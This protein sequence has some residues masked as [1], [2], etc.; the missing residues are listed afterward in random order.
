MRYLADITRV[1]FSDQSL[2]D[3]SLLILGSH[4]AIK[5]LSGTSSALRFGC[6]VAA[7]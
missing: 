7:K 2:S 1:S 3:Q 4:G 5:T 6:D